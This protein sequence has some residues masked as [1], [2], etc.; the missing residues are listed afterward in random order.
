MQIISYT[1]LVLNED[2]K[3][4]QKGM[5]FGIQKSYSIVLMSTEKNAPY[6]DEIFDDG[7][8]EYEGHD[9]PKNISEDKKSID[10]P[11]ANASGHPTENGKFYNA[12]ISFKNNERDPAKI[13]VY[14][15]IRAGVWVDMGFYDLVDSY[16]RNDGRRKL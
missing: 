9:V 4:I 7:I 2:G 13:K 8:I 3:H 1:Q 15:K 6:N 5:N 12:A 10:Q 16:I 11:I 14:R